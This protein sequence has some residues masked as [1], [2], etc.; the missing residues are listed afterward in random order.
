MIFNAVAKTMRK[1]QKLP[2]EI[3]K[4]ISEKLKGRKLT[5]KHTKIINYILLNFNQ[6]KE[7]I[8]L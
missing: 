2:I 7:Y 3:K 1:G 6:E 8:N 5:K 4:K